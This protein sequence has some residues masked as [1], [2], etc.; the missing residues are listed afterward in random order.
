VATASDQ[1]N[2][3]GETWNEDQTTWDQTD[4]SNADKRLILSSTASKL[5]LMDDTMSFATVAYTSTLERTGISFGNPSKVKMI[6]SIVPRI[7]GATGTVLS[8]Q[9]GAYNDAEKG[10]AWNLA[11]N[12]T[13]GSSYKADVLAS[14]RFLGIRISGASGAWRL[15]SI[16]IDFI[17]KGAR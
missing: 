10:I 1:W 9:V 13:V 3:D 8:I 15:K 11:G 4:I 5:Y 2:S 17:E 14:G 6:R 7:D 12:Y 16:D